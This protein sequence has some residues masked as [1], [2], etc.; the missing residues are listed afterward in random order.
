[1]RTELPFPVYCMMNNKYFS[2]SRRVF[3]CPRSTM[4]LRNSFLFLLLVAFFVGPSVSSVSS[5]PPFEEL[6]FDQNVDHFNLETTP[7]TFKQRYLVH[8]SYWGTKSSMWGGQKGPIFFYTGNEGSIDSFYE[9]SG[10][11][12]EL[13]QTF[14]ALVILPSSL[15]LAKTCPPIHRSITGHLCR[16]PILWQELPV[17]IR[18][19]L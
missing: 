17:W 8:D 6:W 19:F 9:N 7:D 10:F 16:A 14:G 1:M 2:S 3:L 12:F 13:A 5:P 4:L 18:G 15:P 11:V